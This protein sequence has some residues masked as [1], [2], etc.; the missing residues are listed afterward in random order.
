[1]NHKCAKDQLMAE[2]V[3]V[4]NPN[5]TE[6]IT[7]QI[8]EAI[9]ELSKELEVNCKVVTSPKGPA[10]IESDFDV[11][12]AIDPMIKIATNQQADA[13]VTACFSDP[14]IQKM[15]DQLGVPVLGIGESSALEAISLGNNVGIISSVEA[16]IPRHNRYWKHLEI[17]SKII[18]DIAT[19][20]GVLD[21]ESEE[22]YNDIRATGEQLTRIGADVL[23]LGC[24]GMAHLRPRLQEEL[25]VPIVEPCQAALKAATLIIREK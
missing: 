12:A 16:A 7:R 1:M 2:T 17:Q 10:A 8:E 11:Q 9:T 4:I 24:T 5:S 21:L 15:R 25:G 19:G 6:R 13:Y 14:G 3:L 22:A 20:R 18:A 23:V